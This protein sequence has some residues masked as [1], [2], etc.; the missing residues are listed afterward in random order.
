MSGSPQGGA[1]PPGAKAALDYMELSTGQCGPMNPQSGPYPNQMA[2]PR[3]IG[4]AMQKANFAQ[5]QQQQQQA[6]RQQQQAAPMAPPQQVDIGS[7]LNMSPIGDDF[8][9]TSIGA[10]LIES[11]VEASAVPATERVAANPDDKYPD[12]AQGGIS[13]DSRLLGALASLV[14]VRRFTLSKDFSPAAAASDPSLVEF[15]LQEH[16]RDIFLLPSRDGSSTGR[17][18]RLTDAI[19]VGINV[20]QS[21][22]SC[23]I[24]LAVQIKGVRGN[25]YD[26]TSGT[27]C[28]LPLYS[29][30]KTVYGEKGFTIHALC[31]HIDVERL[32]RYGHLT[33]EMLLKTVQQIPGRKWSLVLANSPIMECIQSNADYFRVDMRKIILVERTSFMVKN[34][35][36]KAC[37]KLMND[38]YFARQPFIGSFALFLVLLLTLYRSQQLLHPPGATLW[39][40]V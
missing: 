16:C 28:A 19:L 18:G 27:R 22:S 24:P 34:S 25:T 32:Q 14:K 29:D 11:S 1:C 7:G 17:V 21:T 20:L 40:Q 10:P 8:E 26:L 3:P 4:A 38:E 33:P 36:I 2:I 39:S 35:V 37:I 31:Q 5:R 12:F 13:V 15:T 23:P 6:Q 9:E 30:T